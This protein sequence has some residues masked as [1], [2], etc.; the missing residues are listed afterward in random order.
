MTAVTEAALSPDLNAP[1]RG[2]LRASLLTL[3]QSA[4]H[5]AFQPIVDVHSGVVYGVEALL[6]GHETFGCEEPFDL[7]DRFVEADAVVALEELL[8]RRAIEAFAASVADRGVRLFLNIDG[9]ALQDPS[10]DVLDRTVEMLAEKGLAPSRICVE[11]SERSER[12]RAM[13]VQARLQRLRSRGVRFAADD[14]G[15]GYSELKLLFDGAVDFVKIDKYFVRGVGESERQKVSCR[16]Y[17]VLR[18]CWACGSSPRA[19]RPKATSWSA[20]IWAAIWFRAGSWPSRSRICGPFH[21]PIR[22]WRKSAGRFGAR[23]RKPGARD[24]SPPR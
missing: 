13:H 16:A 19:W 20:A 11:L 9:R 6:R 5:C 21:P 24:P 15:L 14:F 10:H 3:A 12:L 4:L 18:T 1:K 23:D 22:T 2:D 8:H 17:A 7:L